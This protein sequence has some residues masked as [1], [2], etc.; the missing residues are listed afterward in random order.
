MSPSVLLASFPSICLWCSIDF[1]P[2]WSLFSSLQNSSACGVVPRASILFSLSFL[3]DLSVALVNWSLTT[4]P[5]LFSNH[6]FFFVP[7]FSKK[8]IIYV[9]VTEHIGFKP[10]KPLAGYQKRCY[11][12]YEAAVAKGAIINLESYGK[13]SFHKPTKNPWSEY[14]ISQANLRNFYF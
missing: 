4:C 14:V 5:W 6:R 2:T 12:Q 13:W 8:K 7:Y 1:I 9:I 3:W 11:N 10:V